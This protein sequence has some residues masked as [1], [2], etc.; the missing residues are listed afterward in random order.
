MSTSAGAIPPPA[1]PK[2]APGKAEAGFGRSFSQQT[3]TRY[4]AGVSAPATRRVIAG[5]ELH[6]EL[7]AG[8]MASVHLGRS[9]E[10]DGP[11]GLVAIKRLHAHLAR[12]PAFAD[13]L[14]Q[15][16]RITERILH[17][18][19]VATLDVV[20][21]DHEILLV[22]EYVPGETVA[23]LLRAMA[24]LGTTCSVEIAASVIRDVLRGLHA[25]HETKDEHGA[26]LQIVHRDVS[27]QNVI[28]STSGAAKVL[29]FGIAKAIGNL[30]HTRTNELKGKIPYMAPELLELEPAT[31]QSDVWAAAVVLWEL[32]CAR[33]LFRGDSHAGI[34]AQVLSAPIEAPGRILGQPTPLDEIVMRGLSRDR[35]R[36]YS[37]AEDIADD[38]ERAII[39]APA[40]EVAAW[41]E[42]LASSAIAT[43]RRIVQN[44]HDTIVMTAPMVAREAPSARPALEQVAANAPAAVNGRTARAALALAGVLLV[45]LVVL[46]ASRGAPSVSA[47]VPP[48][49]ASPSSGTL[50]DAES[51]PAPPKGASEPARSPT[52]AP[53]RSPARPRARPA[54][55]S[56]MSCDPPY[57]VDPSGR[58]IFKLECID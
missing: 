55:R 48:A 28:V 4:L 58:K 40:E 38:I 44:V 6:A 15:E 24:A 3:P 1:R 41:V 56:R 27:P 50:P 7:A 37:T 9:V 18:N 11:P 5:Y 45:A 12:D 26:P 2:L 21:A 20:A 19:V 57:T 39:P 17:P 30:V 52:P 43:R 49:P 42:S 32:L 54:P 13:V 29:D 8:G 31:R 25:A 35:S 14:L 51:P 36:R 47:S 53:R 46:L 34:W 16:A 23:G 33:R 22:M 10:P